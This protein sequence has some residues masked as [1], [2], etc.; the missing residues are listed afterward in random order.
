MS[1][2]QGPQRGAVSHDEAV[3]AG[4]AMPE[5]RAKPAPDKLALTAL[6]DIVPTGAFAG[7]MAAETRAHALSKHEKMGVN[8]FARQI[9]GHWCICR[10]TRAYTEYVEG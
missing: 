7:R 10:Q 4:I 6:D 1:L 2:R 5:T 9:K 3:A 8:L